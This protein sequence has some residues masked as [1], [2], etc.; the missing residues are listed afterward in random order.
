M[1]TF[2]AHAD[3]HG[4]G[5]ADSTILR[6]DVSDGSL[7]EGRFAGPPLVLRSSLPDRGHSVRALDYDAARGVVLVGTNQCNIMEVTETS[8]VGPASHVVAPVWQTRAPRRL[9]GVSSG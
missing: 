6:W 4:P 1:L 2:T 5:G 8:Q 9:W 3:V 7:A